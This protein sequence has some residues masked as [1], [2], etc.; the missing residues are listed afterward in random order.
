MTIRLALCLLLALPIAA[1][2]QSSSPRVLLDTSHGPILLEL[3][4][5]NTPVTTN[6]FL[7]YV[8]AGRYDNTL[9]Q[10]IVRDFVV[11]GGGL[12]ADFAPISSFA[13]IASER[14]NPNR[15]RNVR[16]T[17]AMA[18]TANGNQ[19]NYN[20]ATSA[21]FFNS[22]DNANLDPDFTA[23]G[24][25]VFGLGTLETMNTTPLFGGGQEPIIYPRIKRAVRTSAFPILPL[26]TGAWYDPDK[27]GR[28]FNI[29]IG[30][31]NGGNGDL[32]LIVYWYDFKD[33]EQVWMSGIA[34]FALGAN[35][36]T[37]PMQIS[38]GGQFGPAFNPSQV[39]STPNWGQLTVRFTAC[40]RAF[41]SYTSQF[42]NGEFNLQRLTIP[43]GSSCA[44]G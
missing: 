8:D 2:A 28:G 6:N 31:A 5:A 41:L 29:E 19:Y 43:S 33:G 36:V 34:P 15:L 42:G 10:R 44:G 35:Q 24:R 22:R 38:R 18:L 21:F 40:D 26:H 27:A 37:V 20:S 13:A 25:I 3:D 30:T 12:K 9:L 7:A 14:N 11:Q 32:L 1:F 23:F 16:G 17:I 4:G 39:Q